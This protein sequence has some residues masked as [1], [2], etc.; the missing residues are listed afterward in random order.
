MFRYAD[1]AK[2]IT[3]HAVVNEDHNA[4]VIREL[5]AEVEMLRKILSDKTGDDPND[6]MKKINE[7][8]NFMKSMTQTWEEK[9]AKSG[10]SLAVRRQLMEKM[11]LHLDTKDTDNNQFYISRLSSDPSMN[12]V[13]VYYLRENI[14]KV[15]TSSAKT[16]Q[17]IKL[18][19]FG[20]KSEHCLLIK[21]NEKLFI[22]P[23]ADATTCINGKPISE[24]MKLNHG[25]RILLGTNNFFRVYCPEND[26]QKHATLE[27]LD[28]SAAQAEALTS[29]NEEKTLD[30][31]LNT[32]EKKYEEDKQ[33]DDTENSDNV[34]KWLE[35]DT[36]KRDAQFKKSLERLKSGWI[37][38]SALVRD[39]NVVAMELQRH[40]KYSIT[41]QIP[42]EKL[43]P[44]NING[45]FVEDPSILVKS[46]TDG[47][48]IWSLE[49]LDLR[50]K[51]MIDIYEK[52]TVDNLPF[53]DIGKT[54]PDPFFDT[55]ENHILIGVANMFLAPLF[56][57][58]KFEY[59]CPII[60]Q[61]VGS[62]NISEFYNERERE[63]LIV[64]FWLILLQTTFQ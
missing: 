18:N 15:G 45:V 24:L 12:E 46:E 5:R 1:R 31:F 13:L 6:L 2:K 32:L 3:N 26:E 8:E 40:V 19:G 47:S 28:W 43:S 59:N 20:I 17:E 22:E 55:I 56:H 38:A 42:P 39:A 25:D 27:P 63:R 60:S 54:L 33:D 62:W 10:Q 61:A 51:D 29:T 37:R 16:E 64:N 23:K 7:N 9:L 57:D 34:T 41:L 58:I 4:R 52:V 11:G 53:T 36:Q 44:N 50:L 48:Q 35:Q 14:T 49:K 30:D 21:R